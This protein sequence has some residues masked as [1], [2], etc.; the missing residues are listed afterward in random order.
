MTASSWNR[1]HKRATL[2]SMQTEKIY[3]IKLFLQNHFKQALNE[4]SFP[5]ISFQ[6]EQTGKNAIALI[7]SSKIIPITQK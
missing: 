4:I 5:L 6:T 1:Q 7:I 3:H 2:L